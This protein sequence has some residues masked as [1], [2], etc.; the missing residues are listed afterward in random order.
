VSRLAALLRARAGRVGA[1]CGMLALLAAVPA[2]A[3][4]AS[5]AAAAA[6]G[7]SG[8]TAAGT[9]A[10]GTS[11]AAGARV[12]A[13]TLDTAPGQPVTVAITSINPPIARPGKPVTVTGTVTNGTKGAVSGLAV[14]LWS[15]AI[16]LTSRG[17]LASYAS[18]QLLVDTP[19]P[20][21][22]ALPGVLAPGASRSWTLTAPAASLGLSQF[23]VYPLAAQVSSAGMP[24]NAEHTFLPFW[25]GSARSAQLARREQIAW[26]WPLI[27]PPEQAAC[28]AL[29]DNNLASSFP[30]AG[31]LGSLLAAGASPAGTAAGLTWAID[32]SLL[33]SAAT[34]S[35]PYQVGGSASCAGAATE[36]AS[37]SARYWLARL[38]AVT[39][40]QDFFLTP[41][42][43]VDVAALT[44]AGLS[45]DLTRAYAT[46]QRAA[47]LARLGGTQRAAGVAGQ[48][49]WP[50]DGVAD[51]GVLGNLAAHGVGTVILSTSMM[52]PPA[53]V[54]YTPSAITT[55][56]DGVNAGLHVALADSTLTQILGSSPA[57]AGT[58]GTAPPTAAVVATVQRFLAETAMIAAEQPS[59]PRSVVVAPPRSWNPVP[60]LASALLAAT[61]SA[62]WLHPQ[63]LAGLLTQRNPAGQVARQAPPAQLV[64]RVELRRHLLHRVR[65][66]ES[67]IQMQASVLHR[68]DASYLAGAVAAIESSAWRGHPAQ[69]RAMLT[70]VSG[71]LNAQLR[72]IRIIDAGQITLTGK[73]GP[74]PVSIMNRL[75]EPVTVELS[76][77]ADASRVTVLTPRTIVTIGPHEQRTVGVRV[78]SSVAGSTTLS[79]TLLAPDGQPMPGTS[80]QLTVDATHFGSTA[81]VIIAVA[82]GLF[83][84]TSIARTIRRSFRD[85]GP[86]RPDGPQP[87]DTSG[88]PDPPQDGTGAEPGPAGPGANGA[89]SGG[90]PRETDTFVMERMPDHTTAEERDEYASA[91]GRVEHPR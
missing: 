47:G 58:A 82:I 44:H 65:D 43:D 14:Q 69:A 81:L 3:G 1:A 90:S 62:P 63:S 54:G 80:A 15:S 27:A 34:M 86:A 49:T 46:G 38:R 84:V 64:S 91:P 71:Y 33:T 87:P 30:A 53:A 72:Q 89:V 85:S 26:I 28:P 52:P 39:A 19:L 21:V 77:Q 78:R 18:G 73:S 11:T 76:A 75:G 48:I 4:T 5:A 13:A 79:L 55:T 51:Y 88:T 29:L 7:T 17:E 6:A 36:R 45:N 8:S 50:A 23:G 22:A 31:R 56:P 70:Q 74:V 60:G 37:A 57:T 25:P 12:S 2:A 16:P 35:R 9:S 24:L 83:V 59:I 68:P 32:P 42:A 66:L 41:Y 40:G 61:D 10:A 67:V 20:A